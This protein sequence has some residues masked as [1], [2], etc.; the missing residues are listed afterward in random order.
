MKLKSNIDFLE[1]NK[2]I[3]RSVSLSKIPNLNHK[4]PQ[5]TLKKGKI[6]QYLL[7]HKEEMLKGLNFQKKLEQKRKSENMKKL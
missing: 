7:K 3:L 5:R 2:R 4:T 6:P 1:H